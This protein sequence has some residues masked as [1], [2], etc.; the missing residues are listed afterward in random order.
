MPTHIFFSFFLLGLSCNTS[1]TFF[2][3]IQ[4]C[5]GELL[6]FSWMW[7][8]YLTDTPSVYLGLRALS[9]RKPICL[10]L[11]QYLSLKWW[12]L[13]WF[14]AGKGHV[15]VWNFHSVWLVI[16]RLETASEAVY[17]PVAVET[18]WAVEV[19]KAIEHAITL[20]LCSLAQIWTR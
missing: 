12:D 9:L 19:L 20:S 15:F 4:M 18:A 7:N 10:A 5:I 17:S 8:I 13:V 6:A 1:N 2:W 3:Y 16:I 14:N 11:K